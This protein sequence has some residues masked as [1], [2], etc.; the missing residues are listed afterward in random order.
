[1]IFK[2]GAKNTVNVGVPD[3][4]SEV[5]LEAWETGNSPTL[6][7]ARLDV[8]PLHRQRRDIEC[9]ADAEQANKRYRKTKAL[10]D[11][12]Q[13]EVD[14][15]KED[16]ARLGAQN[17]EVEAERDDLDSRLRGSLATCQSEEQGQDWRCHPVQDINIIARY[18][19]F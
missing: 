3:V 9:R 8:P 2:A 1:M 4:L 10:A 6:A 13:L 14:D 15:L 16:V 17:A 11:E 12:L 18:M 5:V 19:S 7:K